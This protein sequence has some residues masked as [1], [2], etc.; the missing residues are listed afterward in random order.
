M[1]FNE[2]N[3]LS[4]HAVLLLLESYANAVRRPSERARAGCPRFN[5]ARA[6]KKQASATT[7]E[8]SACSRQNE[9]FLYERGAARVGSRSSASA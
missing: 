4:N 8:W 7:L 3:C 1:A 9:G 6:V 5:R 2:A